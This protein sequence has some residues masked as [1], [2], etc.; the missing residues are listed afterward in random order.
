MIP[1]AQS[2]IWKYKPE[3]PGHLEMDWYVYHAMCR[4][5]E[6]CAGIQRM[7]FVP[8]SCPFEGPHEG[9]M[10]ACIPSLL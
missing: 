5:T 9:R 8:G 3:T 10:Y 2:Y 6:P 4:N 7:D 1:E